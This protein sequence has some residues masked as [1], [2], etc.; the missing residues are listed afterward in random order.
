M[1]KTKSDIE[2]LDNIILDSVEVQVAVVQN[3]DGKVPIQIGVFD[4]ITSF[5]V[6][7]LDDQATEMLFH[8]C[9]V[10]ICTFR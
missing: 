10:Q 7:V 1:I 3:V 5:K 9:F 2:R 8:Q 6:V 4:G